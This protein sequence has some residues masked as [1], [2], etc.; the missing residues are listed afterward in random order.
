MTYIFINNSIIGSIAAIHAPFG[1]VKASIRLPNPQNFI[2]P[3]KKILIALTVHAAVI[4]HDPHTVPS[5][6]FGIEA[7]DFHLPLI[8]PDLLVH[9]F[10]SFL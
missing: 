10:I 6:I 2:R 4:R 7:M 8:F 1:P 5:I 3:D 9:P